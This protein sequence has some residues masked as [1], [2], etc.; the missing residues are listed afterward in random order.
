MPPADD[1][2]FFDAESLFRSRRN[3]LP[4]DEAIFA[5][6]EKVGRRETVAMLLN[7]V[8][9]GGGTSRLPNLKDV[10]EERLCAR[11]PYSTEQ[12]TVK[13]ITHKYVQSV[14]FYFAGS[15]LCLMRENVRA[16][17]GRKWTTASWR[18]R[19]AHCY[20][21]CRLRASCGSS[22]RTGCTLATVPCVIGCRLCCT[23]AFV[24]GPLHFG[25][26]M[27]YS[28]CELCV[29]RIACWLSISC[30]YRSERCIRTPSLWC[31]QWPQTTRLE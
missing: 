26:V 21:A 31:L 22:G 30:R 18:G 23:N 19:E 8:L 12:Q 25:N 13:I 7:N 28:S 5:S 9:V 11:L 1:I 15:V 29:S 20:R 2:G 16:C 17:A 10:L 4:L 24:N 6:I 3:P 27:Q 14:R